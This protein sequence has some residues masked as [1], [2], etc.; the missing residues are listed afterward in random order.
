MTDQLPLSPDLT[1]APGSLLALDPD[2][3]LRRSVPMAAD[4]WAVHLER[5]LIVVDHVVVAGK[6]GQREDAADRLRLLLRAARELVEE[7]VSHERRIARGCLERERE[8]RRAAA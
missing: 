7:E 1:P 2:V 5:A 8:L 3:A 6:K 4:T